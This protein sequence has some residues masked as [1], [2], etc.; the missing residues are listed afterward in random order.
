[1]SK[2]KLKVSFSGGR[3]SAMMSYLIKKHWSDIYDIVFVFANTGQEHE[4]TLIFVDQ[5]DKAFD[6]NLVWV[7]AVVHFV[8]GVGS[9]H[10]IINF[11]TASRNGEPFEEVIK[12]YGVPNMTFVTCNR[13]LKLNTMKSYMNSIGWDDYFSAI[14][15]RPDEKRRVNKKQEEYKILYPLIDEWPSDKQDVMTFWENQEFDLQIEERQ[16]NCVWCWKKSDKKHFQNISKNPEFYDFPRR[17]EKL[18]GWNGAPTYG[19]I[20][21]GRKPRVSFRHHRSTDDLFAEAQAIGIY[22]NIPIKELRSESARQQEF[23]IDAGG[24]GESCEAYEMEFPDCPPPRI[25]K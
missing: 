18:Y 22:P 5:C 21:D 1:M 13:E 20:V 14:G 12:K 2:P 24:C 8:N 15:I 10:K 16:G 3:T 23:D 9:T 19:E 17:M 25:Q 7:E 4:N 6:L 11:E